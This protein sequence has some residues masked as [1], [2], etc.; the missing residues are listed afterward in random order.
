MLQDTGAL[1]CTVG[2]PGAFGRWP[3]GGHPWVGLRQGRRVL[4]MVTPWWSTDLAPECPPLGLA[5]ISSQQGL[6]GRAQG[7]WLLFAGGE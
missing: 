6:E 4:A 2:H 1:W 5:P 7:F 3:W